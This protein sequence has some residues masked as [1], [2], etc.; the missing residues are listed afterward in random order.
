VD[1]Q[2]IPKHSAKRILVENQNVRTK[3][4]DH[5]HSE[6]KFGCVSQDPDRMDQVSKYVAKMNL[7][8]QLK[9]IHSKAD[10]SAVRQKAPKHLQ[11][12]TQ[13]DFPSPT[14]IDSS[15]YPLSDSPRTAGDNDDDR[16][17]D[18]IYDQFIRNAI[19]SP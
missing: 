11:I 8:S 16:K 13:S 4:K 10:C 15:E 17:G 18:S 14:R 12:P 6:R 19:S 1:V 7:H 9:S 5:Q 2:S 3:E